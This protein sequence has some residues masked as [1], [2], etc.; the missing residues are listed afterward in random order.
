VHVFGAEALGRFGRSSSSLGQF[1]VEEFIYV[2]I[3]IIAVDESIRAS[4]ALDFVVS[5]S[6][7]RILC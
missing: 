2:M 1:H 4:L 3:V 7:D 6:I 5:V